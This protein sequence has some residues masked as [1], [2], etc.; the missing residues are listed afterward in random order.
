VSN[1][2]RGEVDVELD[3]RHL[4]LRY[5]FNA[6]AELE[7]LLD[8]PVQAMFSEGNAGVRVIR[9]ALYV[10]IKQQWANRRPRLSESR[11]GI[12]MR[13]GPD[14]IEGADLIAYYGE[15]VAEA[16]TGALGVADADDEERESAEAGSPLDSEREL[17]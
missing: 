2:H 6:L 4:T 8:M 5:D 9:A 1:P 13:R 17:D 11:I 12:W 16:I 10:G 3:G 15:K 14:G 7:K